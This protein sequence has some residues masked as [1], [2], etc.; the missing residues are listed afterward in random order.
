MLFKFTVL[1]YRVLCGFYLLTP[2]EPGRR[3]FLCHT[4][5]EVPDSLGKS[6]ICGHC[7]K[8]FLS[9]NLWNSFFIPNLQ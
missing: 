3:T 8:Y 9:L 7:D 1:L 6:L 5:S 2:L 4:S